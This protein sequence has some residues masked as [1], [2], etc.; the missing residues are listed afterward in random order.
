MRRPA[1]GAAAISGVWKQLH[2]GLP[3]GDK[4]G[5]ISLAI[6]GSRPDTVYALVANRLGSQVL[7]VYRSR[8]GGERWEEVSGTHFAAEGQS[9]YNNT[10]AVHPDDPDT[11]V[12]G[13]NDIHIS[14]DGGATWRRA[15]RWDAAVG[16]AQYVHSDQHA[17]VLPGGNLIYAA[18]DGGVAVSEDLGET[19]S[20]R[21]RG[22]VNTMFYDIDVAPGNGKIFGGGAQ[23][24]GS[25]VAASL[26]RTGTS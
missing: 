17:I 22:L 16:S 3:A 19:W 24:N 9:S 10:I 8:N 13:L 23:D 18:N 2:R 1:S 25:L 26:P 5:R 7:G 14:R 4:T 21:V 11:V 20:M 6:A 15:S 12:C